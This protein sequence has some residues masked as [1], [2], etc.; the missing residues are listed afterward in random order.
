MPLKIPGGVG[1]GLPVEASSVEAPVEYGV[2]VGLT[3][4]GG[5]TGFG[6]ADELTVT[7]EGPIAKHSEKRK[8]LWLRYSLK[9]AYYNDSFDRSTWQ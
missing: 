4:D 7:G 8:V 1:V 9:I 3:V 6:D 5:N 2:S